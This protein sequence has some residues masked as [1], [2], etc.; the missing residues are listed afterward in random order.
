VQ[1]PLAL[2]AFANEAG[3]SYRQTLTLLAL[4]RQ[5]LAYRTVGRKRDFDKHDWEKLYESVKEFL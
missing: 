5:I 3:I 2:S 4:H 1:V